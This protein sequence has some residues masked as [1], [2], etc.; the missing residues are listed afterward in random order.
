MKFSLP[1]FVASKI[2]LSE[3]VEPKITPFLQ[4]ETAYVR[5]NPNRFVSRSIPPFSSTVRDRNDRARNGMF[6][7]TAVVLAVVSSNSAK[8]RADYAFESNEF[9][10]ES[11]NEHHRSC[12]SSRDS[13]ISTNFLG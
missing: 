12:S 3:L 13:D 4:N 11:E 7:S 2:S 10:R 5:I 9:D 6:A 1:H 8:G